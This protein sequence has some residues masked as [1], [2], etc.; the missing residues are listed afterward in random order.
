MKPPHSRC[1]ARIATDMPTTWQMK[2]KWHCISEWQSNTLWMVL[3]KTGMVK[4]KVR[5]LLDSQ[6]LLLPLFQVHLEQLHVHRISLFAKRSLCWCVWR[7]SHYLFIP[8]IWGSCKLGRKTRTQQSHA[9]DQNYLQYVLLSNCTGQ[10]RLYG[11]LSN[12]T[13]KNVKLYF[14]Y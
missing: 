9:A 12:C 3:M 1:S 14:E 13:V 8:C 11:C 4:F 6:Q 5:T 2:T 10:K 7:L